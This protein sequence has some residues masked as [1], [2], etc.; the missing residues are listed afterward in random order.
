MLM[1]RLLVLLLLAPCVACTKK[2][3]PAGA[4][5]DA[6]DPVGPS[7]K[8]SSGGGEG[9]AASASAAA[10]AASAASAAAAASASASD[11]AALGRAEALVSDVAF[12]VK[13]QVMKDPAKTGAPDVV[14][15]CAALDAERPRLA[16]AEART[17]AHE[18]PEIDRMLDE[19]TRLCAVDVPLLAASDA[20]GQAELSPSQA[21]RRMTCGFAEKDLAKARAAAPSDP[22]VRDLDARMKRMCQ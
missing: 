22:R 1:R 4:L 20:L 6:A 3:R 8:Q 21:S 7:A 19:A 5:A 2:D 14:A 13:H 9:A 15:K 10:A 17:L 18:A 11:R 12:C 16:T